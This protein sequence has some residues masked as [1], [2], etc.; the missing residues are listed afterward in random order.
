MGSIHDERKLIGWRVVGEDLQL[1]TGNGG[2][3]TRLELVQGFHAVVVVRGRTGNKHFLPLRS[4]RTL[5]PPVKNGVFIQPTIQ[6]SKHTT[7]PRTP[8][9][10][11]L[12]Q[13]ASV[14]AESPQP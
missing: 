12:V 7:M 11:K 5:C 3:E 8:L 10:G 14:A 1:H 4:H 6:P 9:A 2:F 13:A